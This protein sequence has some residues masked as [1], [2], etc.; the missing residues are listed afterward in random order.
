MTPLTIFPK[1]L[2]TTMTGMIFAAHDAPNTFWK[3]NAPTSCPALLISSFGIAAIYATFVSKNSAV[4]SP[5]E[6]VPACLTVRTGSGLRTSARTLNAL[7]QPTY[8]K[9]VLTSAVARA[10]PL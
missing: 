3:N 5:S 7:C 10:L 4:T 6:M 1:Q 8:A 2:N 9:C